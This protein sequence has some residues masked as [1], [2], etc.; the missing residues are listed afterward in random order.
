MRGRAAGR[1]LPSSRNCARKT[2]PNALIFT[3][4]PELILGTRITV[5]PL[6]QRLR[7]PHVRPWSVKVAVM[8]GVVKERDVRLD[9]FRG[10]ALWTIFIN[11]IPDNPLSILTTRSY[12]FS[13]AAEI[14][15]LVSG[16]TAGIVYGLL[17]KN[18]SA[19]AARGAMGRRIWAIYKAQL[20][21]AA[22]YLGLAFL[23]SRLFGKVYWDSEHLEAIVAHPFKGLLEMLAL[24][25]QPTM[26]KVLPLYI[27]MMGGV[28]LIL[29]WLVRRPVYTLCAS[30]LLYVIVQLTGLGSPSGDYWHFNPFAWQVLFV[31]GA[32]LGTHRDAARR[33]LIENARVKRI[34]TPAAVSLLVFALVV[35]VSSHFPSLKQYLPFS[36]DPDVRFDWK[37]DL[38]LPR[39]LHSLALAY[40]VAL[41]VPPRV[42]WMQTRLAKP[43]TLCGRH[44]LTVY[45][46][47]ALFS[48]VG[49]VAI[50]QSGGKFDVFLVVDIVGIALLI[51][52]AALMERKKA[53]S[54]QQSE[55]AGSPIR[56]EGGADTQVSFRPD[57]QSIEPGPEPG[58]TLATSPFEK[59]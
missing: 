33:L 5:A 21:V 4:P 47:G 44:G 31:I 34:L 48:Y 22:A 15:V 40:V 39:L 55:L 28:A 3:V 24:L 11:H 13:D 37:A 35:V 32:L 7:W 8:P 2:T 41:A 50:N 59:P 9:F 17:A 10:F 16:C 45:C 57:P 52:V 38:A 14:F 49:W 6:L 30:T 18:R 36:A 46:A 20:L 51:G 42:S 19:S 1:R 53:A 43:V 54:R 29:P 56:L 12:G 26:V 27:F 58:P 25:H 23:A